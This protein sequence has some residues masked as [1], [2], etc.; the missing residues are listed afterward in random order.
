MTPRGVGVMV[1][2]VVLSSTIPNA[3]AQEVAAKDGGRGEQVRGPTNVGAREVTVDMAAAG[4]GESVRGPVTVRL[5]NVNVL[6]YDVQ[7]G[8]DVTLGSVTD[9]TL[10]FIPSLDVGAI[11]ETDEEEGPDTQAEDDPAI[12]SLV[13]D[14][15]YWNLRAELLRARGAWYD[16]GEEQISSVM[17]RAEEVKH[18]LESLVAASDL[19]LSGNRRDAILDGVERL[20][21]QVEE[22]IGSRWPRA[23]VR[24][25]IEE[26]VRIVGEVRA[27]ETL[28]GFAEWMATNGGDYRELSDEVNEFR[29]RVTRNNEDSE[30][31]RALGAL[32]ET[33]QQWRPILFGVHKAQTHAFV[34]K[35]QVDCATW[36]R[37]AR[38]I[39]V[40]V[41]RTERMREDAQAVRAV[42]M[43]VEC[44]SPVSVSAG[45]GI[46]SINESRFGV[47]A[48]KVSG[49]SEG[50]G[51][52]TSVFGTT[53]SYGFRPLAAVLVHTQ[54]KRHWGVDFHV[55]GGAAIDRSETES[56]NDIEYLMGLSVSLRGGVYL[57]LVGHAARTATLAKGWEEGDLAPN[58]IN[59]PPL[60]KSWNGAT[61]FLLTYG[62]R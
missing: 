41:V 16:S 42:V 25:A 13:V 1:A 6:R 37:R 30:G 17:R 47:V 62:I 58:G 53:E 14:T 46:S 55:S 23:A 2:L 35:V 28:G 39:A 20:R 27:L 49:G 9:L 31:F 40:E 33:L 11:L 48:A 26:A 18:R 10:P 61:A 32:K 52:A 24:V 21:P 22:V 15:R 4:R 5:D 19:L 57:S 29:A 43:T 44:P 51:A 54:V 8:T 12:P 38:T 50:S 3:A 45:F 60:R 59:V 36:A 34:R 56:G 7:V